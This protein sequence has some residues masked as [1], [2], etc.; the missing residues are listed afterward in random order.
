M[1]FRVYPSRIKLYDSAEVSKKDF[2][3]ELLTVKELYPEHVIWKRTMRS[4]KRE[5][6]AH[7]LLYNMG[8]MK[9]RTKDVDLDYPQKWYI[10]VAYFFVGSF[11]LL[12]IR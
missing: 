12:V 1:R 10:K 11:A 9:D 7:N 3:K 5:W 4:L 2:D 8:I 6:A